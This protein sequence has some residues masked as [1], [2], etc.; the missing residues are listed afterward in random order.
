M[1][2]NQSWY[3]LSLFSH[4]PN[5]IAKICQWPPISLENLREFFQFLFLI[6]C[7]PSVSPVLT[8][9]FPLCI[10]LSVQASP[11]L[12]GRQSSWT[13]SIISH[14]SLYVGL[15]K[16][17]MG[18]RRKLEV[19]QARAREIGP[20][21]GGGAPC[22]LSL[23]VQKGLENLCWTWA[24]TSCWGPIQ[25]SVGISR[26]CLYSFSE[27]LPSVNSVLGI[28]LGTGDTRMSQQSSLS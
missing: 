4:L 27:N 8:S 2:F 9:R 24:N 7:P 25:C 6:N 13:V 11:N 18:K 21:T 10:L 22:S 12:G 15:A 23:G 14:A 5:Y 17:S 26:Q 16:T 3:P 1:V 19:G 20:S 28:V